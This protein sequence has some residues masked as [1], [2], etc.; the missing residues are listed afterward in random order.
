MRVNRPDGI[1]HAIV[2][3]VQDAP[4]GLTVQEIHRRVCPG[5]RE[6]FVRYRLQSLEKMGALSCE[7]ILG[8]VLVHP[9]EGSE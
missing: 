2:L 1:D 7:R 6:E 5:R 9:A 8:R 4:R 3:F